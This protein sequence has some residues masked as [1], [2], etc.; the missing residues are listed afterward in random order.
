MSAIRFAIIGCGMIAENHALA[1]AADPR[2][3]RAATYGTNRERGSIGSFPY[4]C[5]SGITTSA[6][7]ISI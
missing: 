3:T 7:T 1:I 5:W 6:G 4:L 2:G